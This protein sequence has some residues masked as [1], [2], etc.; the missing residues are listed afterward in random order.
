MLGTLNCFSMLHD[1]LFKTRCKGLHCDLMCDNYTSLVLLNQAFCTR[2]LQLILFNPMIVIISSANGVPEGEIEFF[3]QNLSK[4][5]APEY[6]NELFD[7]THETL[8]KLGYRTDTL[9]KELMHP[10]DSM[11]SQCL[12]LGKHFPC[13]ALF[14][15]SKS[16]LGY[17]CSFNYDAI[18]ENLEM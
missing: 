12:W 6:T 15:I 14:R 7:R 2:C 3:F 18:K 11:L 4:L 5:I 9:M 1:T 17:C 8:E 10:C 16:I 13:N